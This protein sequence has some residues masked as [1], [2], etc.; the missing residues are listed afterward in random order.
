MSHSE[1][2]LELARLYFER[3]DVLKAIEVL[4]PTIDVCIESKDYDYYLEAMHILFRAYAETMAFE[5]IIYEKK[6]L[7]GLVKNHNLDFKSRTHYVLGLCASSQRDYK[8]ALWHCQKAL[9]LGIQNNEKENVCNATL[10]IAISYY[11][12]E[13]YDESLKEI[14]NLQVF[15]NVMELPQISLSAH[16]LKGQILRK[17]QKY[18][19]AIE[20]LWQS[21]EVLKRDRNFYSYITILFSLGCTYRLS[22]IHI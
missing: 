6:R 9:D 20:V 5:K 13:R 15:M 4:E 8:Q 17:I 19:Q 14:Y 22:L 2:N 21:Y 1:K 7:D 11:Y 12:M 18:D 10:G 16:I 3:C